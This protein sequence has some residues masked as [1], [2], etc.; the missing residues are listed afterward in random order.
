M[1]AVEGGKHAPLGQFANEFPDR[2]ADSL[3]FV[4]AGYAIALPFLGWLAALAAAL[5]AYIRVF[6]GALGLPLRSADLFSSD[7]LFL[8]RVS[9]SEAGVGHAAIRITLSP[10]MVVAMGTDRVPTPDFPHP[11]CSVRGTHG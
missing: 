7:A 2:I 11:P 4:A 9:E 3:L 10:T 6:G 8:Y 5:T 1:V